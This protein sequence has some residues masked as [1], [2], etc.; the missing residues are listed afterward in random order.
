MS[1][2][3]DV[4]QPINVMLD[5]NLKSR[6]R[7][8]REKLSPIVVIIKLCGQLGLPLRGHRDDTKY[9]PEGCCRLL[10]RSWLATN[11]SPIPLA[12]FVF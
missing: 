10:F 6:I 7:E 12:F 1:E 9:H 3:N 4:T 8:N 11:L 2:F 5:I